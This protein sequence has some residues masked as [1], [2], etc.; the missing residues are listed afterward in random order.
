MLTVCTFLGSNEDLASE[1]E[2]LL[3]KEKVLLKKVWHASPQYYDDLPVTRFSSRQAP[4]A[5]SESLATCLLA[6][7]D[8]AAVA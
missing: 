5:G 3:A 1:V 6:V 4:H 2:K 8:H 7:Y